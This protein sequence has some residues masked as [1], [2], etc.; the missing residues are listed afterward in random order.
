MTA[1]RLVPVLVAVLAASAHAD[2]VTRGKVDAAMAKAVADI[3][4]CGG[5][6]KGIYD[7]AA[8]D[9]VN[10]GKRDKTPIEWLEYEPGTLE[11][12]AKGVDLACKDADCKAVL[13]KVDT[14]VYKV[15]D[16]DKQRLRAAISGTT[17][18]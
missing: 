15:T 14:I 12:L 16:N 5:P 4:V 1:H 8:Y 13:G 17:L 7:W 18:T 6:Y 2:H 10:W 11:Y 9:A 3:K